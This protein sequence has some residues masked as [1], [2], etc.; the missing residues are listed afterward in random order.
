[1]PVV[2]TL[3]GVTILGER[4]LWNQPLGALVVLSGVAISQGALT[5]LRR[6][7]VQPEPERDL[8]RTPA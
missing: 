7:A 4:L 8:S 3:V 6:P 1:M 5:R 2:A